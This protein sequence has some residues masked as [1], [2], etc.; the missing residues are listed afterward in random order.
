MI[1]SS[2]ARAS[3]SLAG[4]GESVDADPNLVAVGFRL[5]ADVVDLLPDL[6]RGIAVGEIP[7]GD[8]RRHVASGSR[9]AALEYLGQ[10]LD[11]LRLHGI[12][13]EAVEIALQRETVFRPDA[14]QRSDKFLRP[15]IALVMI[16][17]EF[18]NRGELAS[19]PAADDIDG[20]AAIG[21][22]V[23]GSD[24]LGR[25]RRV[26]RAGQDRCDNLQRCGRGKQGMAERD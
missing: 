22:V 14:A 12:V 13:G 3:C 25:Q 1:S 8:T 5:G 7:I 6:L 26:P 9:R 11:R 24:L 23:D 20:D 4:D 16:E 2:T 19:E 17:P 15:A 18:A 10:G 21:Q